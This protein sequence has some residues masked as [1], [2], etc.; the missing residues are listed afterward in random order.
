[1]LW[2]ADGAPVR[3][4]SV[5]VLSAADH[6]LFLRAYD[7]AA[8][9]DWVGARALAAQGQNLLARQLLEWR[10]AREGAATFSEI[11][12]VLKSSTGW[13]GRGPLY[14]RAEQ[15]LPTEIGGS[16][17]IT[18]FG[19]RAPATS[20]GRVKLGDA[21]IDAGQ[22]VRGRTL[23]REGWVGGN[24]DPATELAIA[25]KDGGFI[26]PADDRAR[27]DNLIWQGAI[28]AAKRELARVSGSTVAAKARIALA[29]GLKT[30]RKELQ[31]ASGSS[32][33]ALLFEWSSALRRA[34]QDDEAHA[35]LL[36]V[37]AATL[38]AGHAA[39]WWTEHNIQARDALIAGDPAL[40]LRLIN[41]AGLTNGDDY[42]EAQFLGGFIQL[43]VLKDP[44][45]ALPW[46]Q[47]MEAAVGRPISK[48]KAQYWEGRALEAAGENAAAMAQYRLAA[49]HP[50][51]FYGQLSL[52]KTGGVLHLEEAAI[53][54]A[55]ESELD[56]AALMPPIRILAELGQEADLR[57]FLDA[58]AAAHP[59]PRYLK[60]VMMDVTAWGYPEI[61]VRQAKLLGYG[62]SLILNYSH[63][64]IAL[65]AFA[66]AGTAPPPALVLG[67]I[68]QETEFD[69][70]AIS[71]AG[72]EGL[73]QVMPANVSSQSKVAGL[74]ARRDALLT[75][76]TYNM[77]LGMSEFAGYLTRYNG[78]LILAIAAYNAGPSNAARW[79]KTNGDPRLTGID[80]IDWIERISF[81]E[82]RNYEQRVLENTGAYRARLSG[83]DV[84]VQILNDLYAPG[85]PPSPTGP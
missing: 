70:Y 27:L 64:V 44:K 31:A 79:L 37:S 78:S 72:A 6:E 26:T 18:W 19:L 53:E 8:R 32:D 25:T 16:E 23:V 65:P 3:P 58:D 24:F 66:G 46:F 11:D 80:P 12:A 10:Y 41:H 17:I 52:A 56:S 50:E 7:A 33:P 48:A 21:L 82:T 47:R 13:P 4:S 84:P 75:D 83:K 36:R 81:P 60:R 67:L 71:P 54:A 69:P 29:G 85:A 55:P 9:G 62:G 5:H 22:T 39:R 1:G 15:A 59:S 40:A 2:A 20:I 43:R 51:T 42:S 34:G 63:P 77:Q 73:M 45:A 38:L 30:A 35:M 74:P 57:L 61:A 68:R 28:T 76:T 14:A 49:S